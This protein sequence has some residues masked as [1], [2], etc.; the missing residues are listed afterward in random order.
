MNLNEKSWKIFWKRKNRSESGITKFLKNISYSVFTLNL[1]G[2]L[3]ILSPRSWQSERV[4]NFADINADKSSAINGF[5]S[6]NKTGDLRSLWNPSMKFKITG[7]VF[8]VTRRTSELTKLVLKITKITC[9]VKKITLK[10]TTHILKVIQV[11]FKVTSMTYNIIGVS[12][13]VIMMII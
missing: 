4:H 1:R 12:L 2:S 11:T 7:I 13:K 3:H 10:I 9:K 6:S 5:V 8:N